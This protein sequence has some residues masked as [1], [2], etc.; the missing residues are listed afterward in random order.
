MP[1]L[2]GAMGA[3]RYR[4]LNMPDPIPRDEWL[5]ALDEEAFREPPSLA[6]GGENEGWV[7]LQ[8]LCVTTF[9]H[10]EV[11]FNQYMCWS[12]RMDRKSLPGKLLKALLELRL[13]EWMTETGRERVPAAVKREIREQLELELFPRQLPSVS[14]HDICWDLVSGVVW[15]FNNGNKANESFRILFSKTFGLETR[16]IGALQL[17]ATHKNADAWV[18]RLDAIG[19]SDVRPDAPVI[20]TRGA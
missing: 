17:L 3:R 7:N 15:F 10:E 2:R 19:H 12:L 6:K 4:V 5:E 18:P 16:P 14:S 11:Y 9:T 13:R 1:L 20:P 8:N